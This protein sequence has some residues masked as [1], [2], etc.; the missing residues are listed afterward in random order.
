M[1]NKPIK[2]PTDGVVAQPTTAHQSGE[3][4]GLRAQIYS[5][6]LPNVQQSNN[7]NG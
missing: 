7:K 4:L 5:P 1:K 2:P 6:L 3:L